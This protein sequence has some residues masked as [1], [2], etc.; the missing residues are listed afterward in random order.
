MNLRVTVNN[1]LEK[2]ME[3]LGEW[4]LPIELSSPDGVEYKTKKG[5]TDALTGQV[6]HNRVEFNPETGEDMSIDDP[7]VVLRIDSLDRVPAQNENWAV[8]IPEKPDP[9]SRLSV[10]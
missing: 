6:L 5:T 9:D 4:G 2:S 3:G 10:A 1:D 8:K 7:L